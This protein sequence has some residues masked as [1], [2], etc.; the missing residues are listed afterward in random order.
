MGCSPTLRRDLIAL[1]FSDC[2]QAHQLLGPALQRVLRTYELVEHVQERARA[3]Y[4]GTPEQEEQ[5]RQLWATLKPDTQLSGLVS[6]QWQE[7]SGHG[8]R[9]R[10][11]WPSRV[12]S[13][14]PKTFTRLL[15]LDS[16]CSTTIQLGFQ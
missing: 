14:P 1:P 15:T 7:V 9:Y 3:K 8:A 12:A 4:E 11:S 5:L 10:P 16:D 6:K 2:S 13:E